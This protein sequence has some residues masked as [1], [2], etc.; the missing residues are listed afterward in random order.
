MY[1]KS[2]E[3]GNRRAHMIRE[4][5]D[6]Q[7]SLAEF[8]WPFLSKLNTPTTVGSERVNLL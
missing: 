1:E 2:S 3:G 6:N 4:S 8:D 7:L 5:N